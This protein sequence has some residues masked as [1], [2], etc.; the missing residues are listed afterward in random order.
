MYIFDEQNKIVAS[1]PFFRGVLTD[2]SPGDMFKGVR[3]RSGEVFEHAWPE[4]RVE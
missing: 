4:K 3:M 2:Y 1:T